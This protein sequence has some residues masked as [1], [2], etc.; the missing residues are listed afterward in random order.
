MLYPRTGYPPIAQW[1]VVT[2]NIIYLIITDKYKHI[3]FVNNAK[4]T[5]K[6]DSMSTLKY[7]W[8]NLSTES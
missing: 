5:H 4:L 1:A 8:H 2:N 7:R 3:F 6:S